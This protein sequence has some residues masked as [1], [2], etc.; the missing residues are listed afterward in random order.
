VQELAS[1]LVGDEKLDV[2]KV[3]DPAPILRIAV[4]GLPSPRP[5]LPI[6]CWIKLMDA[7]GRAVAL[8]GIL[9]WLSGLRASKLGLGF[10]AH[11]V[12][13]RCGSASRRAVAWAT[14]HI[15]V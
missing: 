10:R 7:G 3:R 12:R 1:K 2:S 11:C 4:I 14:I 13:L 9:C 8:Q 6:G 5:L 15:W